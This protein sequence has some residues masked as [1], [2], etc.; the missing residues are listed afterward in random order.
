MKNSTRV[1][2]VWLSGLLLQSWLF[3]EEVKPTLLPTRAALQ[4]GDFS[5]AEA[6]ANDYL[7]T[8]PD[9]ADYAIYL[10][11]LAVFHGGRFGE[12]ATECDKV[13][14]QNKSSWM[15]KARFLKAQA[16]LKEKKFQEAEVIYE[17]EANR[18]LS[19]ARKHEIAGVYIQFADE[20]SRKPNAD[21]VGATPPNYGKAYNL[22]GKALGMEIGRELKDEVM[23]KLGKTI[24]A[25]GNFNQA[26]NDYRAY[27]SEFDPDWT[28]AVGSAERNRNQKKENP[29]PAGKHRFEA[30]YAL[31]ESQLTSGQHA[32]ARQNIE[33]LLAMKGVNENESL[34]SDSLWLTVGS[35]RLPAPSADELERGIK[36][37]R[38]F[39]E[40]FPRHK[41]AVNAAWLIG[42]TYRN[43]GRGDQAIPAFEDF[44]AGKG[45]DLPRGEA[46]TTKD[47][48]SGTSP[49]QLLEEW[50]KLAVFYIGEIRFQQKKYL[51]A[52]KAWKRYIAQFPNG[53]HWSASQNGIVNA[54][55]QI[56]VEAVAGKD[57][58][59][60][61]KEF[62]EFLQMHPLD[63]RARQILFTLGQIHYSEAQKQDEAK[64]DAKEV[65]R[66][67]EAAIE[68][69]SK[70]VSKY[71]NTKESSL[72]LYRIGLIYE[73]KIG[74]LEKAL[75]AYRR[76]RWGSMYSHAQSRITVMTQKQLRLEV[77]RKF[78]TNED[79]RIK[80]NVRNMEKLTLKQYF[81]DLEAYFHKVH[82][83]SGVENLDIEL[84][85]PDKT[86]EVK[87]ADYEK[88]KP[89]EQEIVIPFEANKPGVC[90]VNVSEE[91]WE[92][93]TLVIRSDLDL[94]FKS[95]RREL[96]VFVQNML[97]S[98]PEEGVDLLISDGRKVFATGKT[99]KDGVFRKKFEEL[100]GLDDVRVF[101][102]KGGSVASNDVSLQGLGFSQGLTP[103]GFIY[104]DRSAYRPGH[105]VSIR[106]ILREVKDGSYRAPAGETYTVSVNDPQGRMLRQEELK[107]SEFGTFN[108]KMRLDT[109]SPLGSY[110]VIARRF[111]AAAER[112]HHQDGPTF[113]GNFVVQKFQLD[114][115]RLKFSFPQKVYFR[116]ES[117]EGE[118]TAS[119]YWGEP[120]ADRQ[121]R[122]F[123]PD[124]KTYLEKTDPKGRLKIKFDTTGMTPGSSLF[125][126]ASIEGENVRTNE[127]LFLATL[128]FSLS[129][130][131]SQDLILSGEP[132][133]VT[134]T[135]DGPDGKPVGKD[136]TLFVLRTQPPKPDP[137]LEAVP[138]M[139]MPLMPSAEVTVSEH[140]LK[141][142]AKTGKAVQRLMLGKGGHYILR[143][144]GQDR[145][146]QTVTGE[147]GVQISDDED[148]TKLRFFSDSDT[149][150]VGGEARVRLH[151]RL[152]NNLTLMTW[153]GE[154]ILHYEIL[155][156]KKGYNK[157]EFGLKHD[158][159]P[160][161][162]LSAATMD[163]QMLRTASK[164]FNVERELKVQV[165]P[166]KEIFLP[167]EGAEV[168]ITVTD[169]LGRPVAGELS[170]AL[171]DE[172][173]FAIYPDN[174]PKIL[175]F[176][177]AGAY[178]H[179]ELRAG[180]T[181]GFRRDGITKEVLKAYQ[182]ETERLVRQMELQKQSGLTVQ[183]GFGAVD[184]LAAEMPQ[185]ENAPG[186][187]GAAA[188]APR[189][190][191]KPS[192]AI[193]YER[194]IRENAGSKK[195]GANKDSEELADQVM[196]GNGDFDDGSSTR[197][198]SDRARR[199][200]PDA[201][202]WLPA[203]VTDKTGK[204]KVTIP[205]PENTTQ[206]RLT[207]RG[208]SVETLVGEATANA[209]TR[210]DFFV[211]IKAPGL[212]Q[213]G[214]RVRVMAR[215]HNLT[216]YEG[217][218]K[219]TLKLSE[220]S[221]PLNNLS[222]TIKISKQGNTE[223]LFDSVVVPPS[224]ML[225]IEVSAEA[226]KMKDALSREFPIRP[227][228][229][230]YADHEGGI[231]RDDT[232]ISL[233]LPKDQ[234]YTATWMTVSISP[235]QDR[236]VLDL[237]MNGVRHLQRA[238]GDIILPP[239]PP[240]VGSFPG[241]ELLAS[242]SGL[243]YAR[244]IKAPDSIIHDLTERSLSLISGLVVSQRQDGGWAWM[245]PENDSDTF[246]TSMSYW[247]LSAAT[248]AGLPVHNQ[249]SDAA[250]NWLTNQFRQ[251]AAQDNDAKAVILHALSL[252][253]KADFANA[254]RLYRER[255]KLSSPALAYA[256]LT[257]VNLGRKEIAQEILQVLE[258]KSREQQEG[259][260][261]TCWWEGTRAHAWLDDSTEVTAISLL[262][263][264][265][266][267]A[268]SARVKQAVDFLMKQKGC[269]GFSSGKARGPVVAALAD[270]FGHTKFAEADY[271]LAVKV[272]GKLIKSI[273]TAGDQPSLLI[274]VPM[275][276][277]Q[278]GRNEVEFDMEGRG[279]FAYAATIR[280]FSST[281]KDPVSFKYPYIHNRYYYHA[282]LEY[283]GLP[284]S[285]AST[286]P[287]HKL[288]LGQRARVWID[289]YHTS[290]QGYMVIEENIPAGMI[291]VEG[292]LRGSFKH[293]EVHDSTIVMHF[294]PQQQISDISYELVAYATGDYRV[295]PT[296]MRDS[297][298][299]DRMRIGPKSEISVLALGEE[300]SD[301]YVLNDAERYHLGSAYFND[302]NHDRALGYLSELFTRN[303]TYNEKDV[304]RML[305][306]IHTSPD[307]YDAKRI[308]EMFEVLRERYPD[309]F[310]PFDRILV[311]GR[312]YRDIGEFERAWLVLRA[313]IDASFIN[314]SNVSAVLQDEGQFL[315][316]IDYQEDLWR[317]YPDTS[318]VASSLFA[319][320]QALYQQAPQ[321]HLLA[322]REHQIALAHGEKKARDRS[323]D[324]N[325]M[326]SEC[327]R[328]L[329]SF[330]TLY[331][332]SPLG[333][334]AAFSMTNAFLDLKDYKRVVSLSNVFQRRYEKSNFQSSFQYMTALGH[335]WQRNYDEALSSAKLVADGESK[336]RDF[337]RY[338]LG[339]I[340]HAH[341]KPA[342]AIQWYL[343]VKDQY[344]DAKEAIGY[345]EEKRFS[346][347][348]VSI[349][350]PGEPVKAKLKYRNIKEA[351]LQVYRVDLM[352]LYLR[353]K[354]LSSITQ[355]KLAGIKPELENTIELGDGKD[356]ID[357]EK[358]AELNLKE[359]AAYLLIA[360]GD[361]LFA[362]GLVLIT[363]LKI[364]VQEEAVSG[365][366]RANV[367]NAIEGGYKANVHVKAIGTQ[368]TEFRS[369][370]TDLRGIYIA[371]NLR[372]KATVIA[373][374]GE[375]R[376]A[377]YR[378]EKWLGAPESAQQ[379]QIPQQQLEQSTS[380]SYDSNLQMQNKSIQQ[381]NY[382]QFDQM[383]RG[384]QKGVQIKAAL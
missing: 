315:G 280:G 186:E 40:K 74:D 132:F 235:R 365:R 104:T 269:Y 137:V 73:E 298:N 317:E 343:L 372:G 133:D 268:T 56:G 2:K 47:P 293:H 185:A 164:D 77:E 228:G 215:V 148:S 284:L 23:F 326:L 53:P 299:P 203:V 129:V 127:G 92:S 11:A 176:F 24:Q 377:F 319:L 52:A 378:G 182:A 59:L 9:D 260:I 45:F 184:M 294:P 216:D 206:W 19:Q 162:R 306:W 270:Y 194:M 95:S 331:P 100:N 134:V 67:Y 81:L 357:K 130:H 105:E 219:L 38:E 54:Q 302:G 285:V 63:R 165:K 174:T 339:Q 250:Q 310:I 213:E 32:A 201:V 158:H 166:L 110:T 65:R 90:I 346:L 197:G 57:Y 17:E 376:Y 297:V 366:V 86:W 320:S 192:I 151:S 111:Y 157:I 301:D 154:E 311:V 25:A 329:D 177:Q 281:L 335:F 214:D 314:D 303:R 338:I 208:C 239:P 150:Q 370:E 231:A 31:A 55:F 248:R 209:V 368:D 30:R 140:K 373:R 349:F 374:E 131:A 195:R 199:E 117:V 172:A 313:T 163:K 236:V 80:V 142:D 12:A 188:R 60:A 261:T 271:R 125:F 119:Y 340:F 14:G 84:I 337:A 200:M 267:S 356:Y 168:E 103:R 146:E 173:L 18:L 82:C 232:K 118:L 143:A 135:A 348:E 292:S 180:S 136:V 229:L 26:V 66:E 241:S 287:V 3:A 123:L 159:F 323:P 336:D 380:P 33:D 238:E 322:K 78:R 39:L 10:K 35:Y 4:A 278:A 234:T 333:D 7:K 312:A 190:P 273:E 233:E 259:P 43:H 88:Y 34:V 316:S 147:G 121:V 85:Q 363:P 369:G 155:P 138:W 295:L 210:K 46:A 212:L 116:G 120:V 8:N 181:C 249:T 253:N 220:G 382:Q 325:E 20:L 217:D 98:K 225:A 145:F 141:T 274:P 264:S 198:E 6:A 97:G 224:L 191:G 383:R 240:P 75:D 266:V 381:F 384:K 114:K 102:G 156:V 321:A 107:L 289:V 69:W 41:N 109:G 277:L 361:G 265:K 272:N 223:F 42:E 221:R 50:R 218:A 351:N 262:A 207:A 49:A 101:A 152:E 251:V 255:N 257:F 358:E 230:E 279:E 183:N 211:T 193:P 68:E 64:G 342:D 227:Y 175:D 22:Y 169:Q 196:G 364:E 189:T 122:Y 360:R 354:N 124:G 300:S 36:V 332:V 61:R 222:K 275:D 353:E 1:L 108:T 70:L 160:N 202:R 330:L 27:L 283:R 254:N 28:G 16:L 308:V 161:F 153:E 128:G 106:G 286:S 99:G 276:I 350:R 170:L 29:P 72:A 367:I 256:A 282:N 79:A 126:Q 21:D 318:D 96:L 334:D 375:T 171:V 296:V 359:E 243:V 13:I 83:I 91:D 48:Q 263:M 305:L 93:T 87:I 252:S 58:A 345:F 237:A 246:V 307:F 324:K 149:F 258:A 290:Y 327:I 51:D 304:A 352:K 288:S 379:T 244:E 205:M 328:V 15:R 5:G 371:D 226:D 247:A 245:A 187:G 344:P 139:R 62:N 355:V 37:A 362:S 71:P 44:V 113:T 112:Q 291:L 341:G 115:M 309:L 89:I 242:I 76:L 144:A 347:E 179:A 204:A 94:I 167:G 178:R